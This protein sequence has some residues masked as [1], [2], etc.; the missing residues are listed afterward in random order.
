MQLTCDNGTMTVSD[1]EIR[2]T[3]EETKFYQYWTTIV[4][5]AFTRP[6]VRLMS[7]IFPID[8]ALE[9]IQSEPPLGLEAMENLP[10]DEDIVRNIT[11]L[12]HEPDTL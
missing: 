12:L 7:L 4:D 6:R 8:M 11:Q 3:S 5:N 9:T 10:D 2:L 1:D